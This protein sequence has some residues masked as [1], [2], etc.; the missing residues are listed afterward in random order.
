MNILNS[1]SAVFRPLYSLQSFLVEKNK[2]EVNSVTSSE[3]TGD[4][5]TFS[6]EAQKIA[7]TPTTG[8]EQYALPSWFTEFSPSFA[9]VSKG[10][11]A[12]LEEARK[13]TAFHDQL[14][15]D[16]TISLKDAQALKAYIDNMMP[17]NTERRQVET[18]YF[19]NQSLY[20]EYGQI[21]NQY[22]KEA[23]SEQGIV[24]QAD[25]DEKVKNAPDENQELRLSIMEKMFGNPRAMELMNILGIHK[26]TV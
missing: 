10:A 8:V 4:K 19:K 1:A 12:R 25:W 6:S 14:A 3:T 17:A 11:E 15:E 26:P 9:N 5:V 23:M 16:G 13:Y 2:P 20:K 22:L 24:T 18:D 7:A 21:H